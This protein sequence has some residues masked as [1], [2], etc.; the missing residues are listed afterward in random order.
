MKVCHIIFSFIVGGIENMVVDILNKQ[1]E[2]AQ[3][4]LIVINNKYNRQLLD[5]ISSKVRITLINRPQGNRWNFTYIVRLWLLLFSIKPKVIHCHTHNLIKLLKP[6]KQKCLY[7]IHQVG[8]PLENLSN[9]KQLY[10]ISNAVKNDLRE[11]GNLSSILIYNGIN[12]EEFERR[13]EYIFNK[14]DKLKI[15]QISR[16]FHQQKGQDILLKSL[17]YLIYHRGIDNVHLDIVGDG[18]SYDYLKCLIKDLELEDNVK[19][20]GQRDRSWI[21]KN[22]KNYHLLIQPSRTEGFGLTAIEAI[23]A[24]LP[25]IASNID[26]LSEILNNVSCAYLFESEN[27]N[28]LTQTIS[29]LL[30]DYTNNTIRSKCDKGFSETE[31]K[32][33]LAVTA[34]KYLTCY[35]N[36][37]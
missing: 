36:L 21:Y 4:Y 17:N 5:R 33:S 11:R 15:I 32:F 23:A 35:A 27:I 9:Y 8:I 22:L 16:L 34:K 12:F 24:G 18:S 28:N 29:A 20:L 31:N 25:V 19:L 6:F 37:I 30:T 13:T 10:S 7:T 26:G 2:D 1:S 3:V 14:G